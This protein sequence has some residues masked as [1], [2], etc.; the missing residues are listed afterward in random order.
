MA[1]KKNDEDSN[2]GLEI[3]RED[4]ALILPF[5]PQPM[6]IRTAYVAVELLVPR[7]EQGE[8]DLAPEFQRH[9][10]IWTLTNQSRLVESLLLRIPIPVFYVAADEVERWSVVDGIQ[11][12]S[13][14]N[15][16]VKGEFALK[17]SSTCNGGT[18]PDAT[19]SRFPFKEG[20]MKPN[21]SSISLN[22]ALRLK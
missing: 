1:E 15:R 8:I 13:S 2:N 5:N 18:V 11:R 16:F 9:N 21:L 3:E 10:D 17:A 14:I 7:I 4:E 6:R 19:I 20:L 12:M 22:P